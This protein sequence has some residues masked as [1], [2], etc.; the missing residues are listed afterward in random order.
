MINGTLN[1]SV[2]DLKPSQWA[3]HTLDQAVAD[4]NTLPTV[5]NLSVGHA[6]GNVAGQ[7]GLLPANTPYVVLGGGIGGVRAA[8]SRLIPSSNIFASWASSA[9]VQAQVQF[10]QY[11]EAIEAAIPHRNCSTDIVGVRTYVDSVLNGTVTANFSS[12]DMKALVFDA[13][14][15]E[16]NASDTS[17][18]SDEDAFSSSVLDIGRDF[19]YGLS[20]FQVCANVVVRIHQLISY[21]SDGRCPGA[22]TLL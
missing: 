4:L 21:G 6:V 7:D 19:V 11:F 16:F 10:P 12:D 9:P 15:G 20:F 17:N 22:H 18:L 13:A 14:Q 5:F 8:V 2:E 3:Y 1:A